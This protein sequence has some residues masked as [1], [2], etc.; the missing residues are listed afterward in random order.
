M[1]QRRRV[2]LRRCRRKP[3]LER[4]HADQF[5]RALLTADTIRSI[6]ARGWFRSCTSAMSAMAMHAPMAAGATISGTAGAAARSVAAARTALVE[7]C[8]VAELADAMRRRDDCQCSAIAAL[9]TSTARSTGTPVAAA[10]TVAAAVLA[11]EKAV[12]SLM[13][14]GTV[15]AV[16]TRAA[17]TAVAPRH[18]A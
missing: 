7:D 10:A 13:A 8:G 17:T 16:T 9:A 18:A 5:D 3:L 11:I 2:D 4:R 1:T 12:R 6:Y 15:A 14:L